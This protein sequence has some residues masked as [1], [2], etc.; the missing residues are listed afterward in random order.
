MRYTTVNT[1]SVP[2]TT[3]YKNYDTIFTQYY[4][5]G[6]RE[7]FHVLAIPVSPGIQITA[8]YPFW[9]GVS[10]FD[11]SHYGRTFLFVPD[12]L[13]IDTFQ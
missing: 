11:F 9:F 1:M 8:N 10:A 3:M 2:K 13:F 4:I 7:V 6:S 12:I 5:G